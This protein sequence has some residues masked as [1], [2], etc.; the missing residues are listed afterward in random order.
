MFI[1]KLGYF[2]SYCQWLFDILFQ[3]EQQ[4]D[5]SRYSAYDRRVSGFLGE[6]LLDIYLEANQIPYRE[7]PVDVYGEAELALKRRQVSASEA[8]RKKRGNSMS[9]TLRDLQLQE[10]GI[11]R[12]ILD[13]ASRHDLT[14]FMIGGTHLGAVRHRGFIPW[15]DDVD[16]A[17]PR[18]DYET[19]LQV[20]PRSSPTAI[21]S[22]T[23]KSD[24][25]MPYYPA[26]V[27]DP[28]FEILDTSAQVAKTAA[29]G[30]TCSPSTA[31]PQAG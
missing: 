1:M 30:W 29:R 10:L 11:V 21:S 28:S 23:I 17:F 27:V 19:F 4:L 16:L 15:D 6:R 18:E 31:C 26:Q 13:I 2:R 20:A 24:P 12:D 3:V 5:L 22:G 25:D 9:R 7:V 14:V 8:L